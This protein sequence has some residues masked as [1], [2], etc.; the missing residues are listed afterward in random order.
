MPYYHLSN[1]FTEIDDSTLSSDHFQTFTPNDQL[2]HSL[3]PAG[4]TKALRSG[5]YLNPSLLLYGMLKGRSK[6]RHSNRRRHHRTVN[7]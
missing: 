7:G 4:N 3:L 5:G 2:F 1:T 6:C